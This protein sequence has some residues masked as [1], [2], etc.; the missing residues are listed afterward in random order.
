MDDDGVVDAGVAQDELAF[1]EGMTEDE[2][3]QAV[4]TYVGILLRIA[5]PYEPG[6]GERLGKMLAAWANEN[7]GSQLPNVGAMID[8]VLV[9]ND[10]ARRA[11]DRLRRLDAKSYT[12]AILEGRA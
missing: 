10:R 11:R 7:D 9:E 8:A 3:R 12:L 1:V 2:L 6:D 5:Q 4:R